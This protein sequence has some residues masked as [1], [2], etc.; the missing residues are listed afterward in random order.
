MMQPNEL[1]IKN[2]IEKSDRALSDSEQNLE[3]S[4]FVSQNRNY[5]AVFYIVLALAYLDGFQTGK[6]HKL[7]GWFNKEYVYKNKVF[8]MKLN[9]IY[10][11]LMSNREKS[12]YGVLDIPKKEQ[13][14]KGL[15]DAK[16]FVETVKEYILER[17]KNK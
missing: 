17:L 1:F 9:E 8:D 16:F 5:Y 4:L 2:S 12:D 7:L 15:K 6:H 10:K 13:V 11:R 14:E 3:I